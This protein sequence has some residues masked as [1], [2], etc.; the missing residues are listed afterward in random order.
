M[1]GVTQVTNHINDRNADELGTDKFE[2]SWHSTA[3]P[4]HAE[5]QGKVYSKRQVG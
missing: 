1:T 2:V 4:E 3:R 5:W